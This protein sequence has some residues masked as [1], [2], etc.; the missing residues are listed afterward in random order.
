MVDFSSY[1]PTPENTAIDILPVTPSDVA[2][3]ASA[4]RA[5]RC[6]GTGGDLRITTR[7]GETRSTT[8]SA[9]EVLMVQASRIHATGTTA[10]GLEALV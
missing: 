6:T 3:L 2:D 9:G 7:T 4:A 8:I 1:S 5:I 10:T